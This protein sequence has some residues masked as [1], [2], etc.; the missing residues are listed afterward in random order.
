MHRVTSLTPFPGIFMIPDGAR[1]RE[2]SGR[3]VVSVRCQMK[4]VGKTL[5][6]LLFV[7][8]SLASP[9]EVFLMHR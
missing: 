6:P 5:L 8:G 2:M 1:F 7:S 3:K 9:S 4:A